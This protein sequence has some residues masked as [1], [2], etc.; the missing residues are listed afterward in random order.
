[1]PPRSISLAIAVA[2][3][4]ASDAPSDDSTSTGPG[5]PHATILVPVPNSVCEDPKVVSVQVRA[6]Q[7]GC[8][9]PPPAPCTMPADPEHVLGDQATCPITDPTVTLGVMVTTPGEYRIDAVTDRTPDAPT[10]E[11][12]AT[13]QQTSVLVTTVDLDVRA[14]KMDLVGLGMACPDG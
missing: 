5:E 12:Y 4:C 2:I 10:S 8:E 7:I 11:C 9:T 3:G 13:N 14:V 1:M 6:L